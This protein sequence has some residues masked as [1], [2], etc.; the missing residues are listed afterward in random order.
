MS[1]KAFAR[2]AA[3]V[4]TTLLLV[5]CGGGSGGGSAV[6][7]GATV[8]NQPVLAAVSSAA[9]AGSCPNG[10]ITVSTGVD[11]NGNGVLDASETTNTQ[12]VCNGAPGTIG[13]NG[14]NGSNGTNAL[15]RM[16][17]AG[18]GCTTGGTKVEAGL[19]SN[20]NG[21]LDA[22][23]IGSTG[24]VCDGA[25][26]TTGATGAAGAT[27]PAG[28][29]GSA[30]ATG[31]TGAQGPAGAAGATGATGAIGANGAT[32]LMLITPLANGNANCAYGGQQTTSGV[33]S[34]GNN[35]L[36]AA[37]V[38]ATGYA[39]NGAPAGLPWVDA[40]G[41]SAQ[42]QSNTGYLAHNDL[43][44]VVVTLPPNPNVGDIV[45]ING[46]GAGGWRIAQN[47]GQTIVGRNLWN[48]VWTPRETDRNW[49]S[50]AS[51]ADGTKLVAVV[52]GGLIYLSH[53]SGA[54]WTPRGSNWSWSS[55]A[56][57]SDG[58]KL[59]AVVSGGLIYTSTDSG[60]TWTPQGSNQAWRS[61]A[62]SA[63]GTKL[64]AV[65]PGGR[66]YT[67]TP[68]LQNSLQ[69]TTGTS[70][71]I[72]GDRYEAIELLYLGGG[73]FNVLSASGTFYVQ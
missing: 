70:G 69:T 35:V 26:G 14:T 12:Y 1:T 34:N 3:T 17:A 39:C 5:A 41:T 42:A 27:G 57:S 49:S 45:R 47:A 30:G 73:V 61:V 40:T 16:T 31:A 15:V 36:D 9:P 56:S 66:I 67:R 59:V 21:V 13:T 29:A 52:N 22:S 38:T 48:W 65:V 10:G 62:S 7:T 20:G 50:V 54:T 11:A 28:S 53:D 37:E 43:A 44:E 32:S 46:L 33:D 25:I 60:A 68:T 63:D 58:T 71:S 23:E 72:D 64:V 6:T 2:R 18:S 4:L 8:N 51:S 19:D 24:Y 55:V